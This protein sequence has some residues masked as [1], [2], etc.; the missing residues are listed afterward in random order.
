M[1]RKAIKGIFIGIGLSYFSQLTGSITIITYCVYICKKTGTTLD[2]YMS[3]IAIVLMMV[4]GNFCSTHIADKMGRKVLLNLSLLGCATA[5]TCLSCF[6]YM[7]TN[8]YNL[9]S[10]AWVPVVCLILI[11]FIACAGFLQVSRIATVEN[12]PLKVT[13]VIFFDRNL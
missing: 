13:R 9:S 11:V 8:G 4:A 12:L 2:P 5:Q 6:S 1:N 7:S 10:Y 3:S